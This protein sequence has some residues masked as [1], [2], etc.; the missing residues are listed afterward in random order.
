MEN[1]VHL[2]L[3]ANA[4][5]F[6]AGLAAL[7]L[8]VGIYTALVLGSWALT[9]LG[10]HPQG[11]AGAWLAGA[12]SLYQGTTPREPF[13]RAPAYLTVLALLREMGVSAPGLAGAAR[14]LNGCAHLLSTAL[15]AGI[16]WRFWRKRGALLATAL[17]GFYPS[18][19]FLAAQPGPETLALL[20]W[21]VGVAAGLGTVWH[22]PIWSG[23]HLSHRH[24]WA[25]PA[26]AGVAFVLA[27]ALCVSYW[28]AALAWPVVAVFLGRDARGSRTVAA[29]LG[30]GVVAAALMLL[31]N[32][33]GGS[34]QPLAGA[35][36]YRLARAVEISQPWAAPLPAVEFPSNQAAPD[37]L[38]QEALL[39]YEI[40]MEKPPTGLA[41]LNGYW[42]RKAAQSIAASPAHS[43]WR[44]LCK[45]F[46][47]FGTAEFSPGPDFARACAEVGWLRFNP[48]NW[49]I[50]LALGFGGLALGWRS[51]AAGL[52]LMLAA[53]AAVG[54][55][56]WYPT[57]EARAPVAALL[58]LLSG[59]LVAQPWP[60]AHPKKITVFGLMLAAAVLVWYP[61]P[62][63]PA[64]FLIARD[65]RE[66][67]LASAALGD[68][69]GAIREL[70]RANRATALTLSDRGLAADWRFS[71]LL[72]NLPALPPPT[73]LEQQLLD[74]AD[75]A[76]ES[77]AAQFRS[78][79]CL[80]L[81]G[82]GE[83]AVYFW[84]N[85]ANGNSV[86][87]AAARTALAESGHETPAQAQ[88]RA[89]WEIGGGPQ[90]D[91]TLAPFFAKL[92]ADQATMNPAAH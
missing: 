30:I 62:R 52:A 43:V 49:G 9:P 37:G 2:S 23:G 83:G 80:W 42:W 85:L 70:T 48:L 54:A 8:L 35:D 14:L 79:V 28:P 39:A 78:G 57:L 7:L 18:A 11:E 38:E 71:K 16:G 41:V 84:E 58:A 90:P 88:R 25:Y 44:A 6:W 33:W 5:A 22:S 51:P 40:Q 26:V 15:V 76:G 67:A 75:L 82:R 87:G 72:K 77:S 60:Q 24:A 66:R 32:I 20:A 53:L 36:L 34:P 1:S 68:Y 86:W 50:L 63:G 31:Q 10:Q 73:E 46:Q 56:L 59:G 89:A 29:V 27:A 13:F 3:E 19:V 92:R 65:S 61:R 91:P 64:A 81:L 47:F 12:E 4:R 21:L 55:L 45:T 74:N 69:D 17:W